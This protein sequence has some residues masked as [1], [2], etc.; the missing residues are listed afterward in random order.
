[1]NKQEVWKFDP[2][3]AAPTIREFEGLRLEAYRCSAGVWTIG[4]GHA[5]RV[6]PGTVITKEEAEKLLKED[7]Q[8]RAEQMFSC[9]KPCTEGQFI[10]LLSFVFNFDIG[11]LKNSHLLKYHNAGFYQQAADE[12]L[13]WKNVRKNGELVELPGLLERRKKERELYL[14]DL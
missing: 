4:Y 5:S 2:M 9:V 1:M 8:E 13:K 10:A 3:V 14:R 6:I 7:L 12:F 11:R